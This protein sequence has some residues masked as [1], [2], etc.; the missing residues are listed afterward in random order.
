M[1]AEK[2]EAIRKAYE[3]LQVLSQDEKKRMEYEAREKAIRD[4]KQMMQ[5]AL[6]EG[7]ELGRSEG[8]EIGR[9]E[10]FEMGRL[11]MLFDLVSDGILTIPAAAEK[12][13]MDPAEFERKYY[14][15]RQQTQEKAAEF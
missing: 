10:G 5:E 13:K 2:N 8:V 6:E 4:Q 15:S 3:R 9:S 12:E 7:R 14:K 1:P 11:G